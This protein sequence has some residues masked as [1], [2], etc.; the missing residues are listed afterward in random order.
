MG[1]ATIDIVLS[2][3]DGLDRGLAAVECFAANDI[4]YFSA[5]GVS[6][7]QE[8]KDI[9]DRCDETKLKQ[10]EVSSITMQLVDK[11]D[12]ITD[13]MA[14]WDLTS[15]KLE[16]TIEAVEKGLRY[17][18]GRLQFDLDNLQDKSASEQQVLSEEVARLRGL[19]RSLQEEHSK[20]GP[21][22]PSNAGSLD[23]SQKVLLEA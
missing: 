22:V 21:E 14:S 13:T 23:D 15:K 17:E 10:D 7:R 5:K 16:E 1:A 20:H 6:I 8:V 3:L 19:L 11:Y 4:E 2:R 9:F 12:S 18:F